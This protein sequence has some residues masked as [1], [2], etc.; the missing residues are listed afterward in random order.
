MVACCLR[1]A[2]P[3][4]LSRPLRKPNGTYPTL[5]NFHVTSLMRTGKVL[6]I[7]DIRSRH[8][9]PEKHSDCERLIAIGKIWLFGLA[10]FRGYEDL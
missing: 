8:D 1:F 5:R 3:T 9:F 7:P 6:K 4:P 2:S 10:H